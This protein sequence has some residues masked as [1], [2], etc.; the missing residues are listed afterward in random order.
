MLGLNVT[1]GG[2]IIFTL[3]AVFARQ[4]RDALAALRDEQAKSENLLLNIL[5]RSV[6]EQ[7]KIGTRTIA[8]QFSSASIL[9]ADVV[10]FT[11]LA[12]RLPPT[13]VVAILDRL[14]SH[15]DALAEHYGIEKI[16]TIGDCYMVAA[17]V[18]VARSDHA[19]VLGLSR[20]PCLKEL[21]FELS[22]EG[23]RH[24]IEPS[25]SLL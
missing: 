19:R 5:P 23:Q 21:P 18:P 16:K 6:A 20:A 15:F 7:L 17:G 22:L 1:V 13:R 12:E 4:R 3:L 10:D 8:D 2:T 14:F 11:P 9:F 25:Y 24:V